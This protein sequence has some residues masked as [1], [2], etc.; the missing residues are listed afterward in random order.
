MYCDIYFMPNGHTPLAVDAGVEMAALPVQRTLGIKVARVEF[1]QHGL[2]R[3]I[4]RFHYDLPA[5][6]EKVSACKR[7]VAVI[8][9]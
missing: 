9:S 5:V 2:S 6:A 4:G 8:R 3:R 7:V 1:P